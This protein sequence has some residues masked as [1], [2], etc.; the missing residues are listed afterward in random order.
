MELYQITSFIAVAETLNL[1]RAA[2]ETNQS[3][4]AVSTQIKALETHLN[5]RLFNRTPRGMHLRQ[6]GTTLI[7][8]AKKL[9]QASLNLEQAALDLQTNLSGSL[10][11]GINTDPGFLNIPDISR[12]MAHTSVLCPCP[13]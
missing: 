2:K 11:I 3:P 9:I 1:T 7:S 8:T 13:G 4:S 12:T 10:N 5:L 6:E